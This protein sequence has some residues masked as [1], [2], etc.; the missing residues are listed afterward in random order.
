VPTDDHDDV[1]RHRWE[2]GRR[3]RDL[4]HAQQLTQMA[5]AD[6]IGVDH[7]TISRAENGIHA[8][9]VDQAY[10]IAT[11]LDVPSWRLFRDE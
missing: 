4:R 8:I 6:R 7:R 9:S 1:Q 2:V 5:L 3:I 10:R 11:A